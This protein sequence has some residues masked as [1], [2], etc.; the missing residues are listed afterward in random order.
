[1][2]LGIFHWLVLE[3]LGTNTTTKG[4]RSQGSDEKGPINRNMESVGSMQSK[5]VIYRE[6]N[7]S[8]ILLKVMRLLW[9]RSTGNMRRE[10]MVGM[11][12]RVDNIVLVS[13]LAN[14]RKAFRVNLGSSEEQSQ[15]ACVDGHISSRIVPLN[16]DHVLVGPHAE[17]HDPPYAEGTVMGFGEHDI[18]HSGVQDMSVTAGSASV[19]EPLRIVSD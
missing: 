9:A 8:D 4:M 19:S 14:K 5:L 16:S 3:E 12:S 10:T 17:F 13:C 6:D 7:F 11:G 1:M 15:L 2:D 18:L